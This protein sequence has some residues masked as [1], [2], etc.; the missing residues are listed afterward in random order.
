MSPST[1]AQVLKDRL[2]SEVRT[3][4]PLH[5]TKL[6]GLVCS[7]HGKHGTT[8][9]GVLHGPVFCPF[10]DLYEEDGIFAKNT[11]A[12]PGLH[13]NTSR[14]RS[15]NTNTPAVIRARSHFMTIDVNHGLAAMAFVRPSRHGYDPVPTAPI[16][17]P[18]HFLPSS[19]PEEE[20]VVTDAHF[21]AHR[22]RRGECLLHSGPCDCEA[23]QLPSLS[24]DAAWKVMAARF[25]A[26]M[27]PDDFTDDHDLLLAPSSEPPPPHEHHH[28]HHHHHHRA[29]PHNERRASRH[30][31]GATS[32]EPHLFRAPSVAPIARSSCPAVLAVPARV[33]AAGTV[34]AH[35]ARKGAASRL[36]GVLDARDVLEGRHVPRGGPLRAAS[37]P[38]SSERVSLHRR[39]GV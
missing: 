6:P 20:E 35:D 16:S 36:G 18:A 21:T 32:A 29:T 17:A 23:V 11:L 39:R 34:W 13:T 25:K 8:D 37:N 5:P 3:A 12:S 19:L 10:D 4:T 31:H 24:Q 7:K 33:A 30:R 14:A 9:A 38:Y 28:H 15:P 26:V 1:Q 2:A 27:A 22:H